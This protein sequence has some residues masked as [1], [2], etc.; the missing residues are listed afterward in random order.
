M[1][2]SIRNYAQGW[3]AGV[4]ISLIILSFALWGIHS[5]LVGGAATPFAAEVNGVKI[6]NAQFSVAYERLHRQLQS[7]FH[8]SELLASAEVGLK[9]RLLQELIN[10]QVL[11][12]GSL[13][14]DY[15]I[16]PSQ[17]DSFLATLPQFQVNGQFSLV[18]FQQA[19]AAALFAPEDFLDLIKTTLL[20]DQPRLGVIFTSYS[21]PN[22]VADTVTL[23]N[24]ERDI[25]YIILPFQYFLKQPA[26]IPADKILVYYQQHPQDFRTQTQVKVEYLKLSVSEIM[27]KLP[28]PTAAELK[29]FYDENASSFAQVPGKQK[30]LKIQPFEKVRENVIVAF[31]QQ[32]AEEQFVNLREKLANLTYEHPDTLKAAAEALGLSIQTSAFFTKAKGSNDISANNK[33][34]EMAFSEDILNLQNNSDVIQ[35]SADSAVVIRLKSKIPTTLLSLDQ[36]KKQILLKLQKNQVNAETLQLANKIKQELQASDVGLSQIAQHYY[37]VPHVAGL[38]GRHSTKVD[39]AILDIAFAM[40]KPASINKLS[41]AIAK[42]PNG[43]AIIALRAVNSGKL[44]GKEAYAIFAEQIQNSQGLVEYEL[45]KNSLVKRAKIVLQS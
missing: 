28:P 4:I 15:R 13:A 14:Q 6:S 32:K 44:S 22:E 36:V 1:L 40:P 9:D 17:I 19:L 20:I 34:R 35:T 8:S 3:I 16:S 43:Y 18:R 12:Q 21:L 37:L 33:V 27:K 10:T 11:K 42:V 2:Q 39:S 24:Q 45:Y 31:L 25:Q 41:Y 5:Y 7:Q 30:N 38:I 23:V 26:S 29:N